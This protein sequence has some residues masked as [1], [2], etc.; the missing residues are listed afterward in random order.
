[1]GENKWVLLSWTSIHDLLFT[2]RLSYA[3][4]TRCYTPA[5]TKCLIPLGGWGTQWDI[6]FAITLL[7]SNVFILPISSMGIALTSHSVYPTNVHKSA[8]C[9]VLFLQIPKPQLSIIWVM[10]PLRTSVGVTV[11]PT[12]IIS[13]AC[14]LDFLL[15]RTLPTPVWYYHGC[16][17]QTTVY[18]CSEI[19]RLSDVLVVGVGLLYGV[20]RNENIYSFSFHLHEFNIYVS[21]IWVTLRGQWTS[22]WTFP[23]MS[24]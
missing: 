4:L 17:V 12:S 21:F 13:V 7:C 20:S 15:S 11:W 2:I 22:R 23:M 24:G 14:S 8:K 10:I 19:V 9:S 6:L 5:I 18:K 1:M 16:F 3:F